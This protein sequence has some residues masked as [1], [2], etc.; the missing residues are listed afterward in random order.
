[1]LRRL[2]IA[3]SV[4]FAVVAV[5]L[6]VLWV[7][8]YSWVNN[9]QGYWGTERALQCSS[10]VGSLSFSTHSLADQHDKDDWVS[11]VSNYHKS[12]RQFASWT[13]P[14]LPPAFELYLDTHGG[15]VPMFVRFPY[16]I[17]VLTCTVFAAVPWFCWSKRFSLRTMLIATTLV[18]AVLGL[19]CY[20]VR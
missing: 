10:A 12:Q 8:S 5:A 17:A 18:A 11:I 13:R 16:W 1:M 2:R 4:F 3:A 9:I 6:C 7:R 15:S 20:T 14:P 19:V